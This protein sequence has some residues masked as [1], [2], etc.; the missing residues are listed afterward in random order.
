MVIRDF[1]RGINYSLK[2]IQENAVKFFKVD[3]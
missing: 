3:P 2:E 1:K